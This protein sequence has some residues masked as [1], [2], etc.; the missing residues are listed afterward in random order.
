MPG[1]PGGQTAESFDDKYKQDGLSP[2][3]I[4]LDRWRVLVDEKQ[5]IA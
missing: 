4:A 3:Q 5:G 1:H 2:A